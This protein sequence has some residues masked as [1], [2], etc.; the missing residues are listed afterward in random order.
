MKVLV[1]IAWAERQEV[2]ELDLPDGATVG[3]ALAAANFALPDPS[4]DLASYRVGIWSRPCTPGTRLREG[5]RVELY[6]PLAAD[7]KQ[8]RRARA[9]ETPRRR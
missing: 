5:D 3:D 2:R 8:A 9:R 7:P 1:A 6:R 4:I